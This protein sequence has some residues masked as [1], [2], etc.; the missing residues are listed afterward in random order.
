MSAV[1]AT[2]A[3]TGVKQQQQLAGEAEVQTP[4]F[5]SSEAVQQASS[6]QGRDLAGQ[7]LGTTS[8]VQPGA[9]S[10]EA[11]VDLMLQRSRR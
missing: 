9:G 10:L 5:S 3:S 7:L 2:D 6:D 8:D 1:E 11:E 4:P